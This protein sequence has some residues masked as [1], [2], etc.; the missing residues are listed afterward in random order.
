MVMSP[1]GL[2]LEKK[3]AGEGQQHILKT[4]T[5]SRQKGCSIKTRTSLSKSNKYLVMSP[6]W[7]ST[8]SL[9]V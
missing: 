4:D 3:C 1:K 7:G 9:T 5:S 8:R 2:G 6:R